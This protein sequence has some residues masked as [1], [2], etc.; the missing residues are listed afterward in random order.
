ML[1]VLGSVTGILFVWLLVAFFS[2]Q[3]ASG[4]TNQ[5]N[6][7][8]ASIIKRFDERRIV[9]KRSKELL[10]RSAVNCLNVSKELRGLQSDSDK[11][12]AAIFDLKSTIGQVRQVLKSDS[13]LTDYQSYMHK[14]AN[15]LQLPEESRLYKYFEQ[16]FQKLSEIEAILDSSC[17]DLNSFTNSVAYKAG[18]RQSISSSMESYREFKSILPEQQGFFWDDWNSLD[19]IKDQIHMLEKVAKNHNMFIQLRWQNIAKQLVMLDFLLADDP[20]NKANLDNLVE[21]LKKDKHK[22]SALNFLKSKLDTHHFWI[23]V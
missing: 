21:T 14:R 18:M 5:H 11:V 16:S 2:F 19:I 7:D 6:I 23:S 12:N 8:R 9:L 20:N 15:N 1:K 4:F 13:I 17:T 10:T 3:F 22:G